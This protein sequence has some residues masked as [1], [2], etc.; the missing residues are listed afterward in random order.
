[1]ATKIQYD[2]CR[3]AYDEELTRYGELTAKGKIFLG[4]CTF[5]VGGS[6]L[7]LNDVFADSPWWAYWT[8]A[9]AFVSFAIA[10]LLIV[11]SL[12]LYPYETM[13]DPDE[14]VENLGPEPPD[15]E[16][17]LDDRIADIAVACRRNVANNDRRAGHLDRALYAMF[18]GIVLGF[19]SLFMIYL[20]RNPPPTGTTHEQRQEQRSD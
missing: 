12:A 8:F 20:Q 14:Y 16:D 4:I 19:A 5:F 3:S 10:F 13:F 1:M 18:V 11:L 9:L 2:V 6:A 7:K 15:D 17:F